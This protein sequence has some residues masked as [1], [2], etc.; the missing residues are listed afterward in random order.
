MRVRKNRK[1]TVENT[2]PMVRIRQVSLMVP[3]KP[4]S[5]GCRAL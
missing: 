1:T 2:V 3:V 5:G 4:D